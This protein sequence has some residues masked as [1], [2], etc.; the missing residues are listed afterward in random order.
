MI[1][2]LSGDQLSYNSLWRSKYQQVKDSCTVANLKLNYEQFTEI[3]NCKDKTFE[4]LVIFGDLQKNVKL[5]RCVR[6]AWGYFNKEGLT[7]MQINYW[8][9]ELVDTDVSRNILIENLGI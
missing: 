1:V 9:S 7:A 5:S 8:D 2:V 3:V 6:C 4:I